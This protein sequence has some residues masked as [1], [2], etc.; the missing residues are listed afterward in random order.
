MILIGQGSIKM[1]AQLEKIILRKKKVKK[2]LIKS[3][4]AR[5]ASNPSNSLVGLTDLIAL[6]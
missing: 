1:A 4:H 3:F 6:V 5:F 2:K